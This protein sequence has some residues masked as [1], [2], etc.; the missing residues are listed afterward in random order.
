MIPEFTYVRARTIE[1]ALS[2]LSSGEARLHAGGTDLL[3]CL[4]DGVFEAKK[5]VSI[6]RV[7]ELQGIAEG[8]D[9]GLRLGALLTLTRVAED[10][11]VARRYPALAQG[12]S[13]AASPQLRNQGTLGG[14]LC[15]RPRCWYFRGEFHCYRKGGDK[16]YAA[17]G[18]NHYH[19]ILGGESC[20][21]VHPSDL[22]PALVAYAAV[23]EVAGAKGRRRIP[24]EEFFVLPAK[25][26]TRETILGPDEMVTAVVLP[27]SAAGVRS[28]YRKVR[29]RRS[30]DFALAG[31]ALALRFTGDTVASA[32]VVLAGAAPVPWRSAEAEAVLTGQALTE[33][34]VARA[35]AAALEKARPLEHNGYKT[36]LFRGLLEEELTALARA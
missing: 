33:E 21:I 32:R 26:I 31:A 10:P 23:V 28:S 3:G 12:A 19:C 2:H 22:A 18:E 11:V 25:D 34:V 17:S 6:S 27:P 9:G 8:T 30:W 16:C 20:Y 13:E 35:A 15:Q 1:E 7:K 36:Y 29:A 24:I 4:R 5:V 14:N